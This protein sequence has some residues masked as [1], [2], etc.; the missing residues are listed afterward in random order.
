M[1]EKQNEFK[2]KIIRKKKTK[3]TIGWDGLFN[4]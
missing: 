3:Q 1:K 2:K 4:S